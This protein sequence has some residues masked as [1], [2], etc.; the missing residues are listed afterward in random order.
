MN[1]LRWKV[2]KIR[3]KS[4]ELEEFDQGKIVRSVLNAG[5]SAEVSKRISERIQPSE[6]MS[7]DDLRRRVAEELLRE[8]A[9]LCG[10]YMSTRRMRA[11]SAPDLSKGVARLHADHVRGLRSGPGAILQNAGK[12]TEVR[13][14][15]VSDVDRRTINLSKTDMDSIGALE[16]SNVSVRYPL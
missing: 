6:G 2:V 14:E 1:S 3:K 16:G 11:H 7:T 9:M 13:L 4:G 15:P 10:S 12:R 5:A 8:S